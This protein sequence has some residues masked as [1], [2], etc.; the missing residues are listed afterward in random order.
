MRETCE[1]L[2]KTGRDRAEEAKNIDIASCSGCNDS[3][4]EL[5]LRLAF[6]MVE[7]GCLVQQVFEEPQHVDSI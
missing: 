3:S 7:E 5:H 6:S 1:V 2:E 4:K